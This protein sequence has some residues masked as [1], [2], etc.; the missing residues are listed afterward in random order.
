MASPSDTARKKSRN[1]YPPSIYSNILT[2]KKKNIENDSGVW[3]KL[4]TVFLIPFSRFFFIFIFFFYEPVISLRDDGAR[5]NEKNYYIYTREYIIIRYNEDYRRKMKVAKKNR[6][7]LTC[8]NS[9]I[10]NRAKN[11]NS[12]G[13]DMRK[14]S[15]SCDTFAF[16]F[17]FFLLLYDEQKKNRGKRAQVDWPAKKEIR[18]RWS[19]HV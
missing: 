19:I 7:S 14:I 3:K 15:L 12:I 13:R 6:E 18:G 8:Y 2:K 17:L 11:Q 16:F 10:K 1:I 4:R 5:N 9:L